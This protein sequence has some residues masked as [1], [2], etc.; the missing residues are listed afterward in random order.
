MRDQARAPARSRRPNR[1]PQAAERPRTG[2]PHAAP[3][4]L[5]QAFDDQGLPALRSAVAAYAGRLAAADRVEEMV[6]TVH[7]LASNV[8][9]HGGG[10]KPA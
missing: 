9:R 1:P 7:E 8:V 4:P 2:R 10:R 3:R 6:L 5:D